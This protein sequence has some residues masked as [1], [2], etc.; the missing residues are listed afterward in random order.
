MRYIGIRHRVKKTAEGESR[1]TEIAIIDGDNVITYSL[2]DEDEEL[3]WIQDKFERKNS[4]DGLKQGDV[5]AMVLGGSGDRLA[6]ALSRQA[7]KVGA[8]VFRIPSF[9][10]KKERPEDKDKDAI[11]LAKLIYAKPELF[12]SVEV[13]D[14]ALIRMIEIFRARIEAMKAR[15]GCEQRLRQN[16]VGRIFCNK[17]GLFPE[18]EIESL[19]NEA[20][21]ND[22]ILMALVTEEEKRKKELEKALQEV[23]IYR[24]LFEPIQGCGPSIASR[25]IAA[26]QD[27]RR[28]AT[29]A[30]LKTFCGVHVLPNG[31]FARHRKN[32]EVANWHPDARQALYLLGDQFNRRPDSVWGKKLRECKV[33]FRKT[34]PEIILVEG[35]KRYTD[36]HIHK[37]AIWRTLTKFVENLHKEWWRLEKARA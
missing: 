25:L 15:I 34:H 14:R 20:K 11:N 37:M 7:E 16:L 30:Q 23:D 10:L 5:V 32:G 6:F 13:R 35:K 18:G 1:P 8:K 21:A 33:N 4:K 12:Y 29:D 2:E 31:K 26:I 17:E 3:L 28:F 24:Q 27:I 9:Q 19:F 22:T 36:G